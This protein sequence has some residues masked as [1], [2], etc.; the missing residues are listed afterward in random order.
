MTI[1]EIAARSGIPASAIRYYEKKGLLGMPARASG[2]RVY[3]S[4]ILHPLVIIRFAKETGFTL[5]EIR[6]LLRGFPGTDI[7]LSAL[8]EN[9]CR[10]DQRIGTHIGEGTNYEG[11]A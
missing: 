10:K 9:G 1:G 8:E 11:D 7:S 3:D 2:R 4:G 6:L 5:P